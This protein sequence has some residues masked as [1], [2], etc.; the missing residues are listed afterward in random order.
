MVEN[1]NSSGRVAECTECDPPRRFKNK[2]GL[3]GHTQFKHGHLPDRRDVMPNGKQSQ[4]YQDLTDRVNRVLDRQ[5]DIFDHLKN[6][7]NNKSTLTGAPFG[8]ALSGLG[9]CN[10]TTWSPNSRRY[11]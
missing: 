9:S 2:A 1:G 11:R 7:T 3:N 5:D 4:M 6:G 8:C 10:P